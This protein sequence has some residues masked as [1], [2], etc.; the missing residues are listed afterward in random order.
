MV[1]A[2]LFLP[3]YFGQA[4]D[5]TLEIGTSSFILPIYTLSKGFESIYTLDFFLITIMTFFAP[6]L[7]FIVGLYKTPVK[8]LRFISHSTAMY[9]A[10][11]TLSS[12]GVISY[13]VS[14]KATFLVTGDKKQDSNASNEDSSNKRFDL[15]KKWRQL[16][17]KS[18]PDTL[19]VQG[20]EF[21]IGLI[22]AV[23][24]I[25]MFQISFFGLCL[26]FMLMPVLHHLGWK[27]KLTRIFAHLPFF[28]ILAGIFLAGL[29]LV[30]LQTVFFGYGFHF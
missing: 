8:L 18:H 12:I 13:L 23:A 9:A 5:I 30:G 28:M 3:F 1:I 24:S 16:V 26:A 29:S 14:G 4:K 10:L 17:E 11:G 21:S 25:F 15:K 20:L 2:N 22:F 7:C 6:V 27:S 19:V